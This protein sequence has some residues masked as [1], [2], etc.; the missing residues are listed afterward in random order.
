MGRPVVEISPIETYHVMSRGVGRML[1]FE[2]D[3]DRTRFLRL[4]SRALC[5]Y[6]VTCLCW[7]LMDNH[8]HFLLK[9]RPDAI[10]RFMKWLLGR[11]AVFFNERHGREGH[12]FQSRFKRVAVMD[13]D[14][15]LATFRY[16]HQNPLRAGLTPSCRYAWSSFD[17]YLEG[18]GLCDQGPL[19]ELIG[20]EEC[21][22]ALHEE[23]AVAPAS[24]ALEQSL[25]RASAEVL[26]ARA[27]ELLACSEPAQVA[28]LSKEERNQ[29]LVLLHEGGLSC[30]QIE[31]VTGVS[32]SVVGR[33]IRA[34]AEA[35]WDA[36]AL[37]SVPETTR[38]CSD[39]ASDAQTFGLGSQRS[40]ADS[41]PCSLTLRQ[42][43]RRRP[44]DTSVLKW[45]KPECMSNRSYKE[46]I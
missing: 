6:P 3:E 27:R 15:L 21:F 36:S 30:R 35:R 46:C 37:P 4:F 34:A 9:G 29:S 33:A 13:E 45:E 25:R 17:E 19:W 10:S 31:L 26:I 1:I 7:T 18:S 39:I 32:K 42:A 2:D 40:S 8:V 14:Q 28:A 38:D 22:L 11:Y 5:R 12:L 24:L 23:P 43:R 44:K 41:R 20:N 16:I